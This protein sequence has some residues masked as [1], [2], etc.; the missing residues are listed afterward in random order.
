MGELFTSEVP[1]EQVIESLGDVLDSSTVMTLATDAPETPA[2]VWINCAF[3]AYDEA[4]DLIFLSAT[5]AV[6]SENLEATR[7]AAASVYDPGE[8]APGTKR[9][10][11][12]F[13]EAAAIDE[14]DLA[15]ALRTYAARFPAAAERIGSS[16]SLRDSDRKR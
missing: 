16:N 9:G 14:A 6:H 10:V 11:Q 8:V 4:F 5:G 1:Y 15:A 3:F 7:G 2:G 13:G 12:L